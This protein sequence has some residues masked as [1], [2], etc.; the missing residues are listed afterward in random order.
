MK[1]QYSIRVV[2]FD[3]GGVIAEEG[4]REGLRAIARKNHLEEE[5]FIKKANDIIHASGY[6][7]GKATESDFWDA[8]REQTGISGEDAD[9]RKE[10][11]SRFIVRDWMLGIVGE[12]NRH[13]I[14]TGILSDQTDWLDNLNQHHDFF[15]DFKHVFNS[16]HMGNGKR[17]PDHFDAVVKILGVPAADVLFIDDDAGNCERAS[18]RGL[19]AI[20][21]VGKE[22][23]L[24]RV[25]G[26]CPF[27]AGDK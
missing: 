17:N 19:H 3:F 14:L 5:V 26:Y 2:L 4:F 20:H 21:Y 12:I 11:L 7:L 13:D 23:F 8:V 22:D 18:Q 9:F 15:K 10:C 16:Y 24:D 25:K 27:I 6:L 1:T